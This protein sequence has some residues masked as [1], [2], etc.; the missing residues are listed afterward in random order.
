MIHLKEK[1]ILV[2]EQLSQHT[3]L[4]I[5]FFL[6]TSGSTHATTSWITEHKV[7]PEY[8]NKD[9]IYVIYNHAC[10]ANVYTMYMT[11]NKCPA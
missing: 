5:S 9:S 4:N 1:G 8:N 6:E 7:K 10:A 11:H 2:T 3:T